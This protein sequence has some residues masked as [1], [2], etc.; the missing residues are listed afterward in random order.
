MFREIQKHL[1][2]FIELK[3]SKNSSLFQQK[4][5]SWAFREVLHFSDA[6]HFKFVS[7]SNLQMFR[8]LFL[9]NPCVF[10]SRK[11]NFARFEKLYYF[12]RILRE[13]C[14]DQHIYE[15]STFLSKNLLFLKKT[16]FLK[17]LRRFTN[18]VA[19]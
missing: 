15:Q 1:P 2:K 13:N 14:N 7:S 11:A 3:K 9:K 19:F 17:V 12:I 18:S 10:F 4:P 5:K 6:F 16:P 8:V